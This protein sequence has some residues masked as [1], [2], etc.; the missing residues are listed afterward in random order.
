[1]GNSFYIYIPSSKKQKQNKNLYWSW[2]SFFL[3]FLCADLHVYTF[4]QTKKMGEKEKKK[5]G[6]KET[7]V[8]IGL[9][10][11]CLS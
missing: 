6:K 9:G 11:V 4:I 3:E 2:W 5:K 7:K 1:M 8:Y 10:L